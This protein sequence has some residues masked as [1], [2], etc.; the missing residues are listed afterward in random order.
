M[1]MMARHG[2][3][4]DGLLCER[5]A[6]V[7]VNNSP[8]RAPLHTDTFPR[9]VAE[10]LD[11]SKVLAQAIFQSVMLLFCRQTP[12]FTLGAK[13]ADIAALRPLKPHRVFQIGASS[14]RH[15]SCAANVR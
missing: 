15:E 8:S 1:P 14:V 2:D 3:S 11:R 10:R 7:D 6:L 12:S 9:M 5:N 13:A 4:V